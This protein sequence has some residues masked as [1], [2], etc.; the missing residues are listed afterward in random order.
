VS[1]ANGNTLSSSAQ[2]RLALRV[3]RCYLHIRPRVH[4]QPLPGFVAR[5]GK[6]DGTVA[7]RHPPLRLSRAVSRTL[8][9][10]GRQPTCL[11]NALVLY[12]LL[13]EQGDPAE[14]VIGLPAEAADKDAHA[15]VEL[16]GVDLG[17]APGR[18]GH[19]ELARFG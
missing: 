17:P 9:M 1:S 12:R 11:V 5:L 2:A 13:R 3:L 16:N 7:E 19:A 6:P 14:V 18:S 10:G 8:R 15:W 4:R